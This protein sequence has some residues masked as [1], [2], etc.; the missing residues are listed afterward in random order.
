M[1]LNW[2]WNKVPFQKLYDS[3]EIKLEICELAKRHFVKMDLAIAG[4][5]YGEGYSIE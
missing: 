3:F 5:S 4:M 2:Y 1:T